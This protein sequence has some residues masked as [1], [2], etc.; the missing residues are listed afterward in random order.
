MY[1]SLLFPAD[2]DTVPIN[3]LSAGN[4]A[5]LSNMSERSYLPVWCP[6]YNRIFLVL[7]QNTQGF[8]LPILT[9]TI[10]FNNKK[11]LSKSCLVK[12]VMP[13]A[14]SISI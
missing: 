1:L 8:S 3:I 14:R 4:G 12:N 5:T 9:D 6:I 13:S 2:T 7:V 11:G 10:Q